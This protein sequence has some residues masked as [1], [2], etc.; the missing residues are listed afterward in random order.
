VREAN[1]TL[2]VD[3]V[4]GRG[5]PPFTSDVDLLEI[6]GAPKLS[7]WVL[8]HRSS[9]TLITTDLL[10]NVQQ[11]R[12]WLT[13][14]VLRAAGTYRR[15]A[16]SRFVKRL[17]EDETAFSQSLTQLTQEPI[18]HLV[19]SHGDVISERTSDRLREALS[20]DPVGGT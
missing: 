20:V 9:G 8:R 5:S 15:L 2:R 4:L 6:A 18:N 16:I 3:A 10:F 19:M 17:V 11:P 1:S 12:G 13:P 14:W 7:E